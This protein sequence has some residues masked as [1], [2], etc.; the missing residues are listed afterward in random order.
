MDLLPAGPIVWCIHPYV[1]GAQQQWQ[2]ISTGQAVNQALIDS[3][4]SSL[5]STL[6][7]LKAKREE[8]QRLEE[9][10]REGRSK[11]SIWRKRLAEIIAQIPQVQTAL[12]TL[13]TNF[14]EAVKKVQQKPQT[15]PQVAKDGKGLV[16]Q[17]AL[18][19][20]VN[21]ASRLNA[22]ETCEGNVQL[23]Y[24]D[25]QGRMRQT[26][27]DATADGKNAAFEQ[28]IPD[29]QRACLNF[30]NSNSVVK[31]NKSLL[32]PADWS[33]EAWFFYPLPETG[34]WNT[35][36][37]GKDTGHQILVRNRKQLGTY[38]NNDSLGQYFYDSGFNMELLPQGWHHIAAV[39]RGDTTL[40]YIDGKKVGDIKAKAI[41]DAEE[42]LKKTPN[43]AT[44][45]KKVE[46]IKKAILKV[47][48]DV[49][50]IGNFQNGTQQFGKVAEVRIWGVALSDEE[51]AVNSKTLLSGNEP[52]LLAYYPMNEATGTEVRD[53]TGNGN[54]GKVEGAN[55]WGCAA[56]IGN[57]GTT[58][59]KFDGV[60]DCVE[61]PYSASLNPSQFTVSCWV[62]VEGGQGSH[63]S[64]LTSRS[65]DSGLKGY[66]IYATPENKWE[67]FVGNGSTWQKLTGPNVVLN[68]WTH[69]TGTYDG[70][71]LTLYINGSVAGTLKT[72]YAPNAGRPLR[73]G[74]GATEGSPQFCFPGQIA[75]V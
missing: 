38:L 19:G 48:S 6:T 20:F 34:E 7:S 46:D 44:A 18:L 66:V 15:M 13:N 9:V 62:K 26:N 40:F 37:R 68:T 16:T 61:V 10:L 75:N 55:W 45:K 71:T 69:L 70:S 5:D 12:N 60:N 17:G 64:P 54:N 72:S 3:A 67:M 52:G 23:S 8:L 65:S 36:T 42:N 74:A 41:A 25:I 22:I 30:G 1:F 57:T 31:L 11:E 33:I 43:D 27:Y 58:V 50:A 51:I 53:Q 32:L 59:M 39:G 28:W 24:F 35:L 49:Y 4:K 63:R 56:P 47:S 14:L 2:I 29:A 73:I 21:P